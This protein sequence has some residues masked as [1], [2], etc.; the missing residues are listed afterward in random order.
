MRLPE[1]EDAVAVRS[2]LL[3]WAE[4]F[5][6]FLEEHGVP[7]RLEQ[8]ISEIPKFRDIRYL[9]QVRERDLERARELEQ[10]YLL[11][12]N[13]DLAAELT[14]LPTTDRCPACGSPVSL[15]RSECP[16]CGL[17]LD[18]PIVVIDEAGPEVE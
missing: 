4:N 1:G 3:E 5:G 18:G 17:S 11:L 13:P 14:E 12:E 15:D 10:E 16:S 8:E 2:G 7:W 6:D 9:V